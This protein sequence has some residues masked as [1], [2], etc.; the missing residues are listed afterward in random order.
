[1]GSRNNNSTTNI[2]VIK[3]LA[4]FSDNNQMATPSKYPG[5]AAFLIEGF[6]GV[7]AKDDVKAFVIHAAK[8]SGTA[9]STYSSKTGRS[10]HRLYELVLSCVKHKF[11]SGV[12]K[13]TFNDDN[14]QA[15][16]TIIEKEHQSSSI[17]GK[18]RSATQ[19]LA[20]T[21]TSNTAYHH[22]RNVKH[23]A[24]AASSRRPGQK[25]RTSS[26]LA[27]SEDE[28]CLFCLPTIFCSVIDAKW[29]ISAEVSQVHERMYHIVRITDIRGSDMAESI[30]YRGH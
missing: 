10:N 18:S 14:L 9:L 30:M 13:F 19:K 20:N 2:D 24:P 6:S 28:R 3:L 27:A 11:H 7:G 5:N 16:G 25:N 26:T 22:P 21:T 17:K 15:S 23:H 29:Y 8:L 1:V 12:N 4:S